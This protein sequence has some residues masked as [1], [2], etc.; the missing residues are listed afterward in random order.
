MA[1]V[2]E[3]IVDLGHAVRRKF[4]KLFEQLSDEYIIRSPVYNDNPVADI[5]IEG[6]D[7]TWL[8]IGNFDVSPTEEELSAYLS[9]CDKFKTFG[10]GR[11]K[12]LA[13]STEGESLFNSQNQTLPNVIKIKRNVLFDQGAQLLRKYMCSV[14]EG[15]HNWLIKNLFP[16]THIHA[17]CTTRR[18]IKQRDTSAKLQDYFLDYNQEIAAK[19]DMLDDRSDSDHS[20]T[21]DS[22][23]K[24]Q[25]STFS[26]RLINGV[27]GCGKTLI[28]INR[29][30]L[31]CNRYPDI[32]IL[33]LI[34][35]K[36]ITSEIK[37]KFEKYL[38][39]KPDNLTIQTFHQFALA[40]QG[41][42]AGRKPKPL[43]SKNDQKP[44]LE[45]VFSDE[46]ISASG[47][48]L[49]RD[50]IWSE[51]EYINEFLIA[52]K[53]TYLDYERQGRGFGLQ[54]KQREVIWSLYCDVMDVLSSP[55]G[56]LPS[57][58]IRE[59]CLAK[60][61]DDKLTK[62]NHVLLDEAQ[63]F[64]PS[65]L[66]LVIQSLRPAGQLFMCADPNQGFLKSRLS[67]KSLG[68]NVRGRTKN[69]ITPTE[70][71]MKS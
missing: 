12:Y 45:K 59:L 25:D 42:V 26:I 34:H 41:E 17:A 1:I 54:R 68:L 53:A 48:T 39:G 5:I 49:S 46:V 3:P 24:K 58:Y 52:D 40:Q 18:E 62:Y 10:D 64:S 57:L 21:E 15:N 7:Y 71:P 27:A 55:R 19:L 14:S 6:P 50:Q 38:Q 69:S 29:A 4:K 47:L 35:N 60:N 2:V 61:L 22:L 13:V 28:L 20:E 66:Q 30:M 65:W 37:Y 67:W 16:E 56:Y 32:E 44:F 36:P 23:D 70:R 33:L 8:M 11:L 31:F 63:F 51:L 9:F 43:F